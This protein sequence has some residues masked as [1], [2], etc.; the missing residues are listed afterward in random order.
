MGHVR[1]LD[2]R[3]SSPGLARLAS[4]CSRQQRRDRSSLD[5][6]KPSPVLETI[7]L[8]LARAGQPMRVCQ[9][10][11]AA[12]QLAGEPLLW[13]SVKAA[14]AAGASG[15]RPRFPRIGH[16]IYQLAGSAAR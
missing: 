12:K 8:V 13:T 11:A 14:L 4:G 16:G 5:P 9:I 1:T 6:P 15:Q 3:F 10:H 2:F 7:T